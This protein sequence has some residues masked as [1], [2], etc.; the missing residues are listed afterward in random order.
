M[1]RTL[2]TYAFNAYGHDAQLYNGIHDLE[3][4]CERLQGVIQAVDDFLNS[5]ACWSECA[6]ITRIVGQAAKRSVARGS[7]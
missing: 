3:T 6:M 5:R 1:D 4:E 7:R 2:S